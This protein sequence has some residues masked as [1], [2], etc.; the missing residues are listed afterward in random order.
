MERKC[1]SDSE[2]IDHFHWQDVQCLPS[3]ECPDFQGTEV[4]EF[5]ETL[6]AP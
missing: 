3:S 1:F 4:T 6:G 5:L 2:P